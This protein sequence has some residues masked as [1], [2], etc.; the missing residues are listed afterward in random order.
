MSYG[1]LCGACSN[2][3]SVDKFLHCLLLS[4]ID[5][6]VHQHEDHSIFE[7]FGLNVAISTRVF[8]CCSVSALGLCWC[9]NLVWFVALWLW[10]P[11]SLCRGI[12]CGSKPL[13]LLQICQV[14]LESRQHGRDHREFDSARVSVLWV[15][16]LRR[17]SV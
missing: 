10:C 13:G 4:P 5:V 7:S 9:I 3:I 16:E 1:K 14:N 2:W 12:P 8:L 15:D 17:T 11:D 6:V